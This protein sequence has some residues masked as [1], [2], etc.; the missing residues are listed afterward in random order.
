MRAVPARLRQFA[1]P[2]G[3]RCRA[4]LCCLMLAQAAGP[5]ALAQS[6]D[7]QALQ[8]ADSTPQQVAQ[9]KPWRIFLEGGLG[10]GRQTMGGGYRT[11]QRASA[12]LG[13]DVRIVPTLRGVLQERVDAAWPAAT[14]GSTSLA[15]DTQTIKDAYLSWQA[16][17]RLI[18][19]AGRINV[20]EGVAL[21][22]NPT[23]W[24]KSGAVRDVVSVDPGS[25]REN[26]QGSAM[27]RGQ[28]LWSGGSITALLS[29]RLAGSPTSSGWSPDWG[30]TNHDTRAL[31]S[32]SQ[33]LADGFTPE[34]LLFKQAG[35]PARIGANLTGL[36]DDSTVIYAEWSGGR[37]PSQLAQAL[38]QAGLRAPADAA[39]RS[40]A[41]LGG[42]YTT[43]GKLSVTVEWQLDNAAL[44]SA[45]WA[46]LPVSQTA[47]YAL[48]RGWVFATRELP[49]R[50]SAMAFA[51]WQDA[52]V[53]HL[54]LS[55]MDNRDLID[56]SQMIWLEARYRFDTAEV[57]LQW[58]ANRGGLAS[59]YGLSPQTTSWMAS[60][61]QYF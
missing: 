44:A 35:M 22:Y 54:D 48:Y 30:A 50:R 41:A 16:G 17:D 56:H 31:L 1:P 36:L 9:A 33:K 60:W 14:L 52:M 10:G 37:E 51:R 3:A 26:R 58:Q 2:A 8:L 21:G 20:H 25:I 43:A 46:R 34:W 7:D 57:A 11:D 61:R 55:A 13:L 12:D 18:A 19:D 47:L 39:F 45:D 59:D 4:A 23:D 28:A 24:F 38:T 6:A 5:E 32:V 40:R 29:P 53:N 27:L 15:R 42:T 49:T